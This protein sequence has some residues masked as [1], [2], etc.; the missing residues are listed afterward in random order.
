MLL[1]LAF[2]YNE[3]Y[4]VFLNKCKDFLAILGSQEGVEKKRKMIQQSSKKNLQLSKW[5]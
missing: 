4:R 2:C 1:F 3:C 5:R